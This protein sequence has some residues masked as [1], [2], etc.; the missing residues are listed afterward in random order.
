MSKAVAAGG[1]TLALLG[2]ACASSG[3][4]A[5]AGSGG[6]SSS[7]AAT[8]SSGAGGGGAYGGGGGGYG[9]GGGGTTGSSGSGGA[10][11]SVLTLTQVNYQFTPATITV[12]QGDTITVTDTNP[13]TP[14]TFTISGTNIDVANDPMGSEDVTIDLE[15]GIY[16]FFCRFHQAR[17]MTGTLT[18]T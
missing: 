13:S 16:D 12:K 6:D 15:P 14:H 4:G 8:G 17:G 18:V 3:G 2:A 5:N 9:S 10:G 7:S 1:L 11:N